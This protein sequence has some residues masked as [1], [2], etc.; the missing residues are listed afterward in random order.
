MS[1]IVKVLVDK[2]DFSKYRIAKLVGVSWNTVHMWYREVFEPRNA[3]KA[4]LEEIKNDE[5]I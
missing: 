1:N 3:Y 4:K 2:K 5:T